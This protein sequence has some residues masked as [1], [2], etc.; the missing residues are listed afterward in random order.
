[1][2]GDHLLAALREVSPGAEVERRGGVALLLV[3]DSA[4][5]ADDAVRER[6]VRI[7]ADHGVKEL[8]VEL[9]P[10]NEAGDHPSLPGD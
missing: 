6:V 7:A 10:P 8:A 3:R 5:F 4:P 1:M 9:M 2:N